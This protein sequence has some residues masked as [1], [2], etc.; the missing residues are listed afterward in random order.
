MD[1]VSNFVGS[2][3]PHLFGDNNHSITQNIDFG[4]KTFENIL[5][6]QM[7]KNIEQNKTNFIDNLGLPSGVYIGDL[8]G[9]KPVFDV[10]NLQDDKVTSINQ[11]E[12]SPLAYSKDEKDMSTS[13]YLTFFKSIFDSKPSLTDTSN[14][15]LFQFE[16]KS[17]A[18]QYGKYSKNVVTNLSEFV[19][20]AIKLG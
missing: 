17:A 12:N 1:L 13:E 9:A 16:R 6:E 2:I 10:Q 7:S 14:S 19:A 5:E 18:N 3:S 15:G 11:T 8:D 4:D 20:D